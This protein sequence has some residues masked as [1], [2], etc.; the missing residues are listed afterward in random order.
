MIKVL[1]ALRQ[2]WWAPVAAVL[3]VCNVVVGLLLVFA[4]DDAGSR[5]WGGLFIASGLVIL[6]GLL[7]RSDRRTPGNV[8]ILLGTVPSLL[9]LWLVVPVILAVVVIVGVLKDGWTIHPAV[10]PRIAE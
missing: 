5:I 4:N 9:V 10:R 6:V 1:L 2:A 3:V 8:L 7:S